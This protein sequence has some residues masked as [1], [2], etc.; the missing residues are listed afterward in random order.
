M[1]TERR[2]P[3]R[4]ET[5]DRQLRKYATAISCQFQKNGLTELDQPSNETYS[6]LKRSQTTF[7]MHSG[8]H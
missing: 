6:L 1:I 8:N 7:K 4:F 5:C 2:V 3:T